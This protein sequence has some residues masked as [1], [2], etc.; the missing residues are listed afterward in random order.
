M[1][2]ERNLD[3]DVAS[4]RSG[5]KWEQVVRVGV[6][7]A[8]GYTKDGGAPTITRDCRSYPEVER[9]LERLRREL[10]GLLARARA[11]FGVGGKTA[12]EAAARKPAPAPAVPRPKQKLQGAS[13]LVVADL[14]T[15]EVRTVGVNDELSVADE[16]MKVG[17]FRH[18]V[19]VDEEGKVAGVISHRDV[20][21][22]A[23]AWSMGLGSAAHRKALEAYPV[24]Q[25]MQTK[26]VSVDSRTPLAEAASLLLEHKIGCLPVLDGAALVGILTE[27]DILA[28]LSRD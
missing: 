9:E 19:V 8:F 17:G 28:V 25:V 20:F 11:H 1:A 22:G 6:V 26:V 23:L 4:F 13:Q 5:E 18:V 14:M 3:L 10:D 12:P 2:E 24:K 16:L 21:H 15:S 27:G 7:S